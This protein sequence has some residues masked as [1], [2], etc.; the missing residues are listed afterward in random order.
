[1]QRTFDKRLIFQ[2]ESD[3]LVTYKHC[4]N[5]PL[6]SPSCKF[7]AN[8]NSSFIRPWVDSKY[9]VAKSYVLLHRNLVLFPTEF[10]HVSIVYPYVN[11]RHMT[12]QLLTE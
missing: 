1:M 8:T 7:V 3:N 4:S 10:N 11:S 12:M 2:R 5:I 9:L 6:L